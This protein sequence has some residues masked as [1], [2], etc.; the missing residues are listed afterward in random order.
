MKFIQQLLVPTQIWTLFNRNVSNIFG[1]ET[2]RH[3]VSKAL[4]NEIKGFW[5]WRSWPISRGNVS[6]RLETQSRN[7]IVS[8][9]IT[10]NTAQIRTAYIPIRNPGRYRCSNLLELW[11]N[12]ARNLNATNIRFHASEETVFCFLVPCSVVV[13]YQRFGG[14]CCLHLQGWRATTQ[15]PR[16]PWILYVFTLRQRYVISGVQRE[17]ELSCAFCE[18]TLLSL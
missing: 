18:A 9:R 6:M 3:D 15:Q 13:G 5:K 12:R 8:L 2:D 16:N 11:T 17:R 4:S 1:D 10:G 7:M 14:T